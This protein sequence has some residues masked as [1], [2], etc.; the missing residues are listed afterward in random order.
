MESKKIVIDNLI[1]KNIKKNIND[2]Y[3]EIHEK[4]KLDSNYDDIVELYKNEIHNRMKLYFKKKIK[5]LDLSINFE[6]FYEEMINKDKFKYKI[7]LSKKLQK[8][9]ETEVNSCCFKKYKYKKKLYNLYN[10]LSIDEL[11]K[12]NN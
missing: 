1:K 5:H 7:D 3:W 2:I 4:L 6:N 8:A 10:V 12:L 11:N 9:Y